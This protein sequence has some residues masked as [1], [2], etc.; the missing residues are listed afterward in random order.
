MADRR[1]Q[2]SAEAMGLAAT[3]GTG[4]STS[5]HAGESSFVVNLSSQVSTV[6]TCEDD[7]APRALRADG[8]S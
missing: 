3:R 1:E 6:D 4:P 8:D 2:I 7:S 5:L